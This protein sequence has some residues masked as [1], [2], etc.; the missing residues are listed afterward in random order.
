MQSKG[1][2]RLDIGGR[3]TSPGRRRD[4]RPRWPLAVA[5]A[6]GVFG[7][8]RIAAGNHRHTGKRPRIGSGS[9]LTLGVSQS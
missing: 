5:Y 4:G 8:R 7:T 3:G 9:K 1:F 6:T 2:L